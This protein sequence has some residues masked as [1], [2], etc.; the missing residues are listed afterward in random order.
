MK[1]VVIWCF[2]VISPI[3]LHQMC[4]K[5]HFPVPENSTVVGGC[6]EFD[7]QCIDL[8]CFHGMN[9]AS[10]K[11]F[12]FHMLELNARFFVDASYLSLNNELNVRVEQNLTLKWRIMSVKWVTIKLKP[13]SRLGHDRLERSKVPIATILRVSRSRNCPLFVSSTDTVDKWLQYA[14]TSVLDHVGRVGRTASDVQRSNLLITFL[15]KVPNL[16]FC[17]RTEQTQQLAHLL[18]SRDY[19]WRH[20]SKFQQDFSYFITASRSELPEGHVEEKPHPVCRCAFKADGDDYVLITKEIEAFL[21]IGAMIRA[22]LQEPEASTA[23]AKTVAPSGIDAAVLDTTK[24]LQNDRRRY[25]SDD[26][27]VSVL[28]NFIALGTIVFYSELKHNMWYFSICLPNQAKTAPGTNGSASTGVLRKVPNTCSAWWAS[29]THRSPFQSGSSAGST[30][31]WI[32]CLPRLSSKF[33]T[34]RPRITS[35]SNNECNQVCSIIMCIYCILLS[36]IYYIVW[37]F[38]LDFLCAVLSSG[39][40]CLV[41]VSKIDFNFINASCVFFADWFCL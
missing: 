12:I 11:W 13:I 2:C 7:C 27:E 35:H 31:I 30:I 5:S 38:I 14:F 28:M 20:L 24:R 9:F 16:R 26:W 18:E 40:Y 19:W 41:T 23:G 21:D 32:S 33:C 36:R 25:S 34:C 15:C 3:F 1:F 6:L 22:Y 8:A 37:N 29:R 17:L 39:Y 10:E 4:A